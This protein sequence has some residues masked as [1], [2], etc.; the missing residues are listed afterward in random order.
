MSQ[1]DEKKVGRRRL[2]KLGGGAAVGVAAAAAVSG[3]GTRSG[4]HTIK[5]NAAGLDKWGRQ[6]G[7]WVPSCC[8]MCGGQCGVMVHVVNGVVEK[9]E[10]NNWNPNNY[11]NVSQ[12]WFDGYTPEKGCKEGGALCPKGNAAI[13]TLYDPARVKKPL[14]RTNPDKSV[15]ADP[16]WQEISWDQAI[17]EIA[18]K[19]KALRDAGDAHKLLWFAEDHSFNHPQQDFCALFGTPNFSNHSNLCDVAR[20]AS[21]KTVMG[22][23]RPLADFMN[24]R[25]I[26]LFGWN[27]TSAL[28]WIHLGRIIPRALEKG[29]KLVVVDPYMSD[30]A[31]RAHEWLS[32]RP[33]T[34]GALALAMANVIIR[35]NLYDKDFVAK[36][37]VGFDQFAAYV[38]DKTPDWAETITSVK[39]SR[40]EALAKELAT[41]KPALVD[42]WSGPGQH[43]NGVQG[44]RAIAALNALIGAYDR[45]GGMVIPTRAG[46]KWSQQVPDDT[47]AA[48]LKQPRYDDLTKFPMGHSSGVY[49]QS[50]TNLAEGKGA[51]QP[52][53]GVIVFQN[54]MM[55]VPGSQNVA[56]ALAKLETLVVVDTMMSETA[57]MADYVIPGTTYLERYDLTTH[58]VTWSTM[59]LRQPVVKPIFGQLAEYEFVTALGRK[60][61]LKNKD[62][63]EY[64][65]LGVVSGQPVEDLTAWY[66]EELSAEIKGGGP[67]ITLAELKALPGATWVE[68]KTGTVYE[69]FAAA[70]ASDQVQTAFYDGDQKTD[71]TLVYDKAKD[72]GGKVI[73]VVV[74]GKVAKGFATPSLRVEFYTK[75][76]ADK[77]DLNGKAVD[78]LPVYEPRD[79][80]PSKEFPLYLINWKEANHTHSR[81]Q[82]NPLLIEIKPSGP[83]VIHPATAASYGVGD[84]DEVW[85]ESPHG[86]VKAKVKTSE[87]MHPEV[88]GLQHGWGHT[89]LGPNA[90]GR[91]TADGLLRPTKADPLSGMALHKEACVKI[92]K[93]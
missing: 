68:S 48:G 70:V 16:K 12:D 85:V 36:W 47:G 38:K 27:P 71:G 3:V 79:W 24:S 64:F 20:K 65:K 69:K 45:P 39:A 17:T 60:L 22:N 54:V 62:G 57:M 44:G 51:Y 93:A 28:K 56:K 21:F 43:S 86:K 42:A 55:S 82:N 81:T 77:K 18:G 41:T 49:T 92:S 15:G 23:D 31:A 80:Q 37:T 75:G 66:E 50:F 14:K 9:I 90:K 73:G 87:R 6:A 84:G 91:G 11:T 76:L 67:G 89:A 1:L 78:P 30:T 40:I 35:E 13:M 29:A 8:N 33:G 52:K 63:K 32:P 34:D 88:V 46:G 26:M 74:G 72:Q 53:M 58:W 83:L 61:G 2:F 5:A 10:P 25:F 7:Q 59:G 19:M 4:E